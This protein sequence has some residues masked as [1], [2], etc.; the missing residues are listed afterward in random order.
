MCISYLCSCR[1]KEHLELVHIDLCGPM[2]TQSIGVSFYFLT[3]IDDFSRKM[4]IYFLNKKSKTFSIFKE[5]KDLLRRNLSSSLKCSG[6]MVEVNMIHLS[7]QNSASSMASEDT[8]PLDTLHKKMELLNERT[9]PS[10]TWHVACCHTR[11]YQMSIGLKLLH[12]HSTCSTDHLRWVS[13]TRFLKNPRL[14][15]WLVL[16]I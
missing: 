15:L 16:H 11:I 7:L 2:Q 1:A 5:F 4:W 10:W 3:F 6:H 13:R 12:A 14:A 8:S 9:K